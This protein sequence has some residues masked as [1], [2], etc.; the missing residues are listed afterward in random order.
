MDTDTAQSSSTASPKSALEICDEMSDRGQ[1]KYSIVVYNFS[2]CAD[3]QVRLSDD[4]KAFK[5]LCNTVFK[6]DTSICK[7]IHLGQKNANKHRHCC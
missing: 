6:F 1:R 7:A 4:I 2:E 5:A 3:R